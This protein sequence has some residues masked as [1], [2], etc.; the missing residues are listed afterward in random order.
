MARAVLEGLGHP[1][2][3][4]RRP[5]G[6][7]GAGLR[8]AAQP[9]PLARLGR[10][11]RVRR[12]R[13][14]DQRAA[15]AGRAPGLRRP[16]R[17]AAR[18]RARP[19]ARLRA[20]RPDR[21]GPDGADA[22]RHHARQRPAHRAGGARRRGRARSRCVD[23]A[24]P[25]RTR[26][27]PRSTGPRPAAWCCSRRPRRASGASATTGSAR[28]PSPRPPA[29]LRDAQLSSVSRRAPAGASSSRSLR[30]SH[31]ESAE[32]VAAAC[33]T[34]GSA[35]SAGQGLHRPPGVVHLLGAVHVPEA[36]ALV[37][38]AV[39]AAQPVALGA[40][41]CR[42]PGPR[43]RRPWPARPPG[44]S[45]PSCAR[46]P[47]APP[48][49]A[50]PARP[51]RHR[52]P[53]RT[54]RRAPRAARA[55]RA[56]RRGS[57]P[58][59]R[60][61]GP[62]AARRR[63]PPASPGAPAQCAGTAPR[64]RPTHPRRGCR[65]PSDGKRG[66]SASDARQSPPQAPRG[67]VECASA[68]L[69]RSPPGVNW[70]GRGSGSGHNRGVLTLVWFIVGGLVGWGAAQRRARR[71]AGLARLPPGADPGHV[72]DAVAGGRLAADLGRPAA[73]AR[74]RCPPGCGCSSGRPCSPGASGAPGQS[75]LEAWAVSPNASFW[76]VPTA[77]AFAGSAGTMIAVLANVITTAWNAVAVHLM[78]R[79]APFRQRRSTTWVD[80]SPVL[81]S[82]VG[83]LLHLVGPG[84]GVDRRR[85]DPGRPAPRLLGRRPV[86]R[87]GHPSA[88]P[89]GAAAPRT[90]CAAGPG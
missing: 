46:R 32:T 90:P 68:H 73:R 33:T 40:P 21:R 86:H 17:G 52:P 38:E 50:S 36:G 65:L 71:A 56:R 62:A 28:P 6:R 44:R 48:S 10:G 1:R 58:R 53:A 9:L 3:V 60:G 63:W 89:G 55:S 22:R 81:A 64:R 2:R 70:A 75:S 84:P 42:R 20:A 8:R 47:A 26:S 7:G 74:S 43:R 54:T 31:H 24:E 61:H 30:K 29:A 51:V 35:S 45:P 78:R 66:A 23:A 88:Q 13:P 69:I 80:Q 57:P 83:L 25:G 27:R 85:P 14:V 18:R 77:A 82:L 49:R 16:A 4:R 19:R 87:I 11:G 72:G 5:A 79:D 15:G 39:V 59:A 12:R 41:R 37:V 76:V 67:S 34:S